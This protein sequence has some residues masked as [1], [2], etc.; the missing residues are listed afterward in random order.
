GR[1]YEVKS[2]T[3]PSDNDK[4]FILRTVPST[5]GLQEFNI[6]KS[7]RHERLVRLFAGYT[8]ADFVHLV[9]E[10]T[11]GDHIARHLSER[12]KYS[13]NTVASVIRQVLYALEYLQRNNLVHLNLQPASIV[14]SKLEGCEVKLTDFSLAIRVSTPEGDVAP[15][16]GHADFIPPEVVVKDVAGFPADIWGVG[17]LAFL[18]LSG[19]SPFHGDSYKSTLVNIALN[20]Y[21][22]I[23]LYENI[24]TEALK[25]LFKVLKRLPRNRPSLQDCLDHK[26]LYLTE[27]AIKER[28]DTV[29]LSN[30]LASFVQ[31][32][33]RVRQSE[34]YLLSFEDEQLP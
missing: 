8:S 17:T 16:R 20:R 30:N 12:R 5:V 9:L 14:V 13:E 7:L 4:K 3:L 2:V 34:H 25:F 26:W 28:E 19:V 27:Q 10:Y 22:A 6:L 29:F 31:N 18:L 21:E 32:Y 23:D 1:F 15:R 33:D 11:E 24:T